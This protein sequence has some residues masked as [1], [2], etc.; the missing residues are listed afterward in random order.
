[1]ELRLLLIQLEAPGGE[2]HHEWSDQRWEKE[3]E[4]LILIVRSER[5]TLRSIP[6]LPIDLEVPIGST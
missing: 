4:H 1:M 6:N 2:S 3:K 5:H